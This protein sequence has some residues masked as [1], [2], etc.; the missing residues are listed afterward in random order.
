MDLKKHIKATVILTNNT[1][2]KSYNSLTLL[3]RFAIFCG[4]V[5]VCFA[6]QNN[7]T[8][9]SKLFSL[10]PTEYTNIDFKNTVVD[11]KEFNVLEYVA[12]YQG[13]GVG[14]G[15]F[16]NDGL[17]DIYFAGNQV[18]DKLYLN[19]GNLQF[20]DITISAGILNKGG[21]STGINI[22]DIN[23]DGFKDIFV[24]KS[25]YDDRPDLR[26]NEL[27]INNGDLTFTESATS[28]GINDP[29]RAM[30]A[31]FFDYDKDG[32][33]D[34]FLINQPPNP[35]T[36]SSLKG[37]NWLNPDLTYRFLKNTGGKFQDISKE[38]GL[39]NIGYGLS[40]VT[41]D[42]NN[43]GWP[44]IYVA[45]D[46]EG[47]DFFYIN[48]QD[49]TFTNKINDYLRH[50]SFFS[51][52]SDVGDINNDGLLDLIVVDMVAEDNYR[53]K[54]N[55][56]GMNPQEFWNIVALGGNY[57][58]MFNTLQINNGVD[59]KGDLNFSEIGQLAGITNTDW[60]WSPLYADFDNNGY[61][62]LFISNGIKKDIRNTD[63]LK[64]IDDYINKIVDEYDIKN[65]KGNMIEIKKHVSLDS[66]LALFPTMKL[67]NHVYKNKG[68][69]NFEKAIKSWGLEE[70]SFSSGAAY[71]DLDNDGDLD[72]V[73][74]NVDDYAFIYQNNS[75]TLSKNKFLNLKFNLNNKET[76]F[77]GTRATIY[78]EDRIQVRELTSARGYYSCS[79]DLMHFG[80]GNTKKIDSLVIT[81]Y[82]G[83]R[84]VIHKIKTGQTL[85]IDR[86]QLKE[87]KAISSDNKKD[88]LFIDVTDG[89]NLEHKHEENVFDDY[90]REVLLPHKMSA[91]GP[92]ITV[93]DIN[94][95]QLEDFYI[96]GS[97]STTGSFFIQNKNGEFIKT[98][99]V[100]YNG[101]TYHE[102]MGSILFDADLDGDL[103]LYVSSGGN[104]YDAGIGLYQDRLYINNGSGIFTISQGVLPELTAS[105]GR[106]IQAD[107]DKDGDIDLF[108]CGRQVPGKYPEPAE[109]YLLKNNWK[110]SGTLNFEKILNNDFLKLGMVTDA[111]W[112]DYD[113]D[114]DLD[115]IVVGEWMPITILEN[116]KGNFNKKN[117]NS[118]LQ[119]ST[120]WWYSIESADI[121]NDGDDD[122]IIGNLGLNYKYKA[123]DEEPFTVNYGDFDQNGKN[124]IILGYYNYGEHYP[125]R[126]RSCSSQQ[127]PNIKKTFANYHE[128]ARASLV[129]VYSSDLLS[130]SLEYKAN[131]FS[132]ICLENLGNGNFKTHELPRLAQLSSINDIVIEDVDLDGNNDV[133][134]AGNMYGSEIE[135]PRNDASIGL[136]LRG[137]GN[138]TFKALTMQDS[139][140]SLPYD[141]KELKPINIKGKKH[142]IIGINDEP[143]RVLKYE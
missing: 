52:G 6:Q 89:I 132:S 138:C 28:Y 62:D 56:G 126:G 13:A 16:N 35:S 120:G 102:D 12:F 60:S 70:P 66:M 101:Y 92:T 133:I 51:M 87:T 69:L 80:L 46:Y 116:N 57:Q 8:D 47:P 107:Y 82:D 105:G 118:S 43:D 10:L 44:D 42:F 36:L 9:N 64:N 67:A 127:I 39:E 106:V 4:T 23:G 59:A 104:E 45:N 20:K 128:F 32:D 95:D 130:Q 40:S 114:N 79:E 83:G 117:L 26:I 38:A 33:F 34:L 108:V 5:S 88:F 137:N 85:N 61:Q 31:N 76:S 124:D 7:K 14:I 86:T 81:W 134:I 136:F 98:G 30:H 55:M 53:I 109:S 139:G 100:N 75:N 73:V 24:C 96:G 41:A 90:E 112:T 125:L 119:N 78:Y 91:F 129:D 1:S 135:T 21:W 2:K 143:I 140:L 18:S 22:L 123:S 121:D 58:Y 25:L 77:F 68:D 27:Y 3:I 93:G 113:N 97:V 115:L 141:V 74:N 54:A 99:K 15:D 17:P 11:T 71:G 50:I 111:K 142:I 131:T 48:N 94:G 72:L 65:P 37:T 29:F 84:S 63:A 19:L 103:D 122:Y 110:E 49:G